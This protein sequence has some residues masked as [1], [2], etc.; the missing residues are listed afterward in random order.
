MVVIRQG[1]AISE[2]LQTKQWRQS[3]NSI[4]PFYL[5]SG[6]CPHSHLCCPTQDHTSLILP[7][8]SLLATPCISR[9]LSLRHGSLCPTGSVFKSPLLASH[10]L[11]VMLRTPS[12]RPYHYGIGGSEIGF[13]SP[14]LLYKI[15]RKSYAFTLKLRGFLPRHPQQCLSCKSPI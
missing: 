3:F 4:Q 10:R 12:G 2:T 5:E 9:V 14:P 13:L 15:M 1:C 8:I 6:S 7:A 11:C